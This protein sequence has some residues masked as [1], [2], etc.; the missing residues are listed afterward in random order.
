MKI[1]IT[2]TAGFI[3]FHL[4]KAFIEKGDE[5][6]GVDNIND[7]YDVDLK[8]ARLAETG[9]DKNG[10]KENV[11]VQS[12]KYPN[13]RFVKIDISNK[14]DVFSL[15][16][17]ERPEY[18]CN[19]AAQAGVRYS[20][21]HPN[22]YIQSNVD[23]FLN[24]LEACRYYPVEHLIYASSSSVYGLNKEQPYTT[25]QATD[26][27][28]SVY[29][30]TKKMNELLAHTYSHLYKIHTTGLRFFTVYG[31]WGRPDMAPIIFT[32]SIVEGTPINIYNEGKM[33][34]DFT[35]IDDIIQSM[36]LLINSKKSGNDELFQLYNI[37]N[38]RSV[39]L[40]DFIKALENKLGV[41]AVKNF[42]PLQPG[43]MLSTLADVSKLEKKIAYRPNTDME[44][45]VGRFVDWYL[46]FYT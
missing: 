22:A 20:L 38:S 14:N 23:G 25:E 17:D 15:F 44:K 6:V 16:A 31:P 43:D 37:G 27:P 18:V 39:C 42:L 28:I 3:G 33:Y 1:L 4:A 36:V 5:V 19:L 30:A 7:Y 45:G 24:I 41:D 40:M 21:A 32:K 8:L 13:Y 29:A 2:G 9:I 46:N 34:R 35:F 12:K 26:S 10:I 11:L